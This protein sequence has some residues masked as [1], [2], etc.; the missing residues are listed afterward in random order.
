MSVFRIA[1]ALLLWFAM[2]GAVFWL[3]KNIIFSLRTGR[4]NNQGKTRENLETRMT[5]M[6][7][8]RYREVEN[9]VHRPIPEGIKLLY[10]R[11]DLLSLTD[12]Y[13]LDPVEDN[14]AWLISFFLPVSPE[15]VQHQ[16]PDVP[17]AF[18]F[19]RTIYGQCYFIP[20]DV[21]PKA[22]TPVFLFEPQDGEITRVSDSFSDFLGWPKVSA[23]SYP[24][25]HG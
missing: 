13:F 6:E 15:T 12:F 8:P 21:D 18:F 24:K 17:D 5:L 23:A 19:A 3:F 25:H 14:A 22:P 11:K 20:F 7:N 4:F 10:T 1:F 9:L 16:W 2:V